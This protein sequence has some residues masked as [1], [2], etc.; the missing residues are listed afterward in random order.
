MTIQVHWRAVLTAYLRMWGW[1]LVIPA[2]AIGSII[3]FAIYD[4][5][6]MAVAA[7]WRFTASLLA[8][9]VALYGA[10]AVI[11]LAM[12][13]AIGFVK[14]IHGPTSWSGISERQGRTGRDCEAGSL[15]GAAAARPLA[16]AA[17]PVFPSLP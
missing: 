1:A 11:Q 14:M 10:F 17:A 12:V 6:L 9:K 7:D 8:F 16:Q 15:S 5:G 2:V 3:G 4:R 13:A